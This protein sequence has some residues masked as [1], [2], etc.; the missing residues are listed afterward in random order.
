FRPPGTFSF[1]NGTHLFFGLVASYLF[2]FWLDQASINRLLLIGATIALLIAIPFSISRSL[3][4]HSLLAMGFAVI[5][6]FQKPRL[7]F[8]MITSFVIGAV[9]ISFLSNYAFFETA[10]N[11]F[12]A[13]FESANDAEGGMQ[14]VIGDR[15]LGGMIGALTNS[16]DRPYFGYGIGMG[17]NVGSMLLTGDRTFLIAEEEWARVIGELGPLLGISFIFIRVALSIKM[18]IAAIKKL[19]LH[20]VLPWML[21]SFGLLTI[22]QGQ[23]AQPT[24]LGFSILIG[25]LILA[26]LKKEE[27]QI[28]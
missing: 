11:A 27:S 17:T 2:Y 22:P 7:L 8:Y 28:V 3:F 25:G 6:S 1:T 12:Y 15:Y 14:G 9:I 20:D 24:S 16:A 19:I 18:T 10:L 23:W 21:L 13:R 5:A 26:S 4:F